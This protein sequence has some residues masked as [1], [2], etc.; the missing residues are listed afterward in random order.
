MLF[1]SN[2]GRYREIEVAGTPLAMGRRIGEAAREEIRGFTAIA[3][4]RV[5][6]TVPISREKALG[7]ARASFPYVEHYAPHMLEE[8]HGMAEGSGVAVEELM[9]LQVRNQFLAEMDSGCTSFA[10]AAPAGQRAVVG[11]NW[12]NDPALNA[13]TVVL[14]R[15]STRL[16]SSHIQKS[17]MPSSA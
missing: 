15:K 6:Q 11:Q 2:P 16:N 9:L 4:E 5:N 3:L 17:R 12:D 10:V 7:V 13:F 1:R 8:L 14:D